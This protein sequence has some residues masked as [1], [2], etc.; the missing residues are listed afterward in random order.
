V[1]VRSGGSGDGVKVKNNSVGVGIAVGEIMTG[2]A[3]SVGPGAQPAR[4]TISIKMNSKRFIMLSPFY[5]L[6]ILGAY[7][8]VS[9]LLG[10]WILFCNCGASRLHEKYTVS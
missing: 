6:G 9:P 7:F 5:L 1:A 8:I 10:V 2:V 3:I 4:I